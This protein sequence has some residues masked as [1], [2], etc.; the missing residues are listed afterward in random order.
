MRA[1]ESLSQQ[2]YARCRGELFRGSGMWP[3]C[4]SNGSLEPPFEPFDHANIT[5]WDLNLQGYDAPYQGE[6]G[7]W[8]KRFFR[9]ARL[10]SAEPYY[11]GERPDVSD[12][13]IVTVRNYAEDEVTYAKAE[14]LLLTL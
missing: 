9:L 5:R 4:W 3:A 13:W 7:D 6:F 1:P 8:L 12:Q 14:Q 11:A 2:R 10:P